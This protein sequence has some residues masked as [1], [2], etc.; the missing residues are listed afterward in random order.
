MKL[1]FGTLEDLELH[2]PFELDIDLSL[3][4]SDSFEFDLSFKPLDLTS[5]TLEPSS[6]VSFS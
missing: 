2:L 3:D 6:K 1:T 4:L 5:L